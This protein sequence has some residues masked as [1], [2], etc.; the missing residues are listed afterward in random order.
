MVS[1]Y[2][3]RIRLENPKYCDIH[4]D[5][6]A[7]ACREV[8]LT[9]AVASYLMTSMG[10]AYRSTPYLRGSFGGRC[11]LNS[12]NVFKGKTL[13]ESMNK[14]NEAGMPDV[15]I[16]DLIRTLKEMAAFAEQRCLPI[17]YEPL[18]YLDSRI[19]DE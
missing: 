15:Q 9:S 19:V 10:L 18:S 6:S 16:V 8:H 13:M 14:L 7:P 4:T 11:F 12:L 1:R 2:T 3:M 17:I 5:T